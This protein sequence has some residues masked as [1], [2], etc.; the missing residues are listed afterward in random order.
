MTF[1]VRAKPFVTQMR[2]GRLHHAPAATTAWSALIDRAAAT[3]PPS[4]ITRSTIMSPAPG[5]PG[6]WTEIRLGA[7]AHTTRTT[8]RAHEPPPLSNSN[9]PIPEPRLTPGPC[10]DKEHGS[11][12]SQVFRDPDD[13]SRVWVAFDWEL[14]DYEKFTSDPE[15]PA[16][17]QELGLQGPPVKAESVAEYDS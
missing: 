2:R 17:F 8:N 16:I 12:G 15:V 6:P 11:R 1:F 5:P 14:E 9:P 4:G 13:P 10:T 3:P 7:R